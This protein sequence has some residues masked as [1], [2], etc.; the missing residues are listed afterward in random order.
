MLLSRTVITKKA[1]Q[2][3]IEELPNIEY[4][5]I[6]LN[7]KAYTKNTRFSEDAY[8]ELINKVILLKVSLF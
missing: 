8:E 4:I 2:K 6:T 7:I 1:L 3:L 5:Q